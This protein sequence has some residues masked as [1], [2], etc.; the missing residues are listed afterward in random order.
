MIEK[1]FEQLPSTSRE[2]QDSIY[3]CCTKNEGVIFQFEGII[4]I[5][6]EIVNDAINSIYKVAVE[7]K[8]YLWNIIEKIIDWAK[9]RMFYLPEIR[10]QII[11]VDENMQKILLINSFHT[12]IKRLACPAVEVF[13][14]FP[15]CRNPRSM[16]L[17][18]Y[19]L[20]LMILDSFIINGIRESRGIIPFIASGKFG[21][22][23]FEISNEERLVMKN[24]SKNDWT[25]NAFLK[26]TVEDNKSYSLHKDAIESK[27]E[28]IKK[29][30]SETSLNNKT[31][32][33][34]KASK[35]KKLFLQKD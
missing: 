16:A 26:K 11:G 20:E 34:D 4:N 31:E 24:N 3:N 2:R 14:R 1:K 17:R 23:N 7:L 21:K 30:T 33:E 8:N 5:R 32:K 28:N 35:K 19:Q 18:R 15:R 22:F 25:K 13:L 27:G 9:K 10:Y 12:L 29:V 6:K